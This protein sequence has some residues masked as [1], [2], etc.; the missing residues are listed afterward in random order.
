[1]ATNVLFIS[2]QYIKDS[3]YIDENID[4]KLLRANILETQDIRILP[5]I[6]TALYNELKTQIAAGN[7]TSDNTTL[8]DTYISNALKYW[9]LHDSAYILQY[10]IMN[11]G[12]VQRSSEN[13]TNIDTTQLSDLM[14]FFKNRAE[15]YSERVTKF[16]I[17]N[18]TVYPL[19]NNP[20]NGV[21]TIQPNMQ[22]YTQGWYLGGTDNTYGLEIDYGK[23]NKC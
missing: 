8:L 22:N 6:G 18:D 19:Y 15:F 2:E 16:L 12:I 20:G 1:M 11:K 3:S 10:K 23:L 13:A 5:M 4:I 7:L 9:V 17:E 21:D 14:D